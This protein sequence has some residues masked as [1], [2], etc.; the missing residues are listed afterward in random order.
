MVK[1]VF[2]I[3]VGAYLLSVILAIVVKR[4]SRMLYRVWYRRFNS[5]FLVGVFRKMRASRIFMPVLNTLIVI[6]AMIAIVMY[7]FKL[8]WKFVDK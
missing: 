1:I 6:L 7:P 2:L 3:G 4:L 5:S 8:L